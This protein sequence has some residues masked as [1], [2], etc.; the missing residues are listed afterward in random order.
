MKRDLLN[1]IT[2]FYHG[3]TKYPCGW[4]K[5]VVVLGHFRP[6][7]VGNL[8]RIFFSELRAQGFKRTPWQLVFPGQTAGIIKLISIQEDG[9][10]EY[11]V[12]FYNDGVI[13]C[14][15]EVARFDSMHWVGPRRYGVEI[16]NDLIDQA[17]TI[18]CEQ[19]RDRIKKLF[20]VKQYSEHCI[21]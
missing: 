1:Y 15:L 2:D 12:R 10:N 4:F 16:L 19:T 7:E 6:D 14:E 20:A 8:Q 13:D 5:P 3:A 18:P 9:V 17:I 21:R 11:H